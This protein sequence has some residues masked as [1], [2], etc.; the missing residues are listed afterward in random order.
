MPFSNPKFV[1]LL[2]ESKSICGLKL[3]AF[4]ANLGSDHVELKQ[5]RDQAKTT[6]DAFANPKFVFVTFDFD[7]PKI[8]EFLADIHEIPTDKFTN[9]ET[10]L[11]GMLK[12][13]Q[14][15]ALKE[16]EK[17]IGELTTS[18]INAEI[19]GTIS[20]AAAKITKRIN[21]FKEEGIDLM[22]QVAFLI[23]RR[24]HVKTKKAYRKLLRENSIQGQESDMLHI[25]NLGELI[26]LSTTK[27]QFLGR[28]DKLTAFMEKQVDSVPIA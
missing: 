9:F 17:A 4:E 26:A 7:E 14:D 11:G 16:A 8:R 20:I 1:L 19:L 24:K 5:L 28:Y 2:E 10:S 12:F 6:Y 22:G 27:T 3:E 18:V 13:L 23:K 25:K 15:T 21:A